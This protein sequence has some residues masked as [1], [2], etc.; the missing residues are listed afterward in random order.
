MPGH[1]LHERIVKLVR[2][3]PTRPAVA[4]PQTSPLGRPRLRGDAP[5]GPRWPAS[6]RS[7]SSGRRAGPGPGAPCGHAPSGE[8]VRAWG[9]LGYSRCC[10]ACTRQPGCATSPPSLPSGRAPRPARRTTPQQRWCC[11]PSGNGIR[12]WT[13]TSP[14]RACAGRR[15]GGAPAGPYPE[16]R[17]PTAAVAPLLPDHPDTAATLGRRPSRELGALVCRSPDPRCAR[18][19]RRCSGVRGAAAGHPAWAGQPRR[20]QTYAGTHR[21]VRVGC[22][23]S[24]GTA[25]PRSRRGAASVWPDDAQRRPRSA[26]PAR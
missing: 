14:T 13:R 17:R 2:R 8:A 25:G 20:G 9:R 6:S 10:L 1:P 3:T 11:S 7:G 22:W 5:A 24:L 21:Q 19:P 16:C 23:Q 26:G 15:P 12:R 4:V 18:L